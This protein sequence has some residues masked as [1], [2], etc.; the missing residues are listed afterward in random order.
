MDGRGQVK[1]REF[2]KGGVKEECVSLI[3]LGDGDGDGDGLCPNME[4]FVFSCSCSLRYAPTVPEQ[5]M[6]RQ[7][8]RERERERSGG[9]VKGR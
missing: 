5:G 3:G 4:R 2:G 1:K 8:E 7:K 9:R 6:E